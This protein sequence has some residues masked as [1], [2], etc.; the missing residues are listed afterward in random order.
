[1]QVARDRDAVVKEIDGARFAEIVALG[2]EEDE[3][4]EAFERR[5]MA[6][7][8]AP[9]STEAKEALQDHVVVYDDAD[10]QHSFT[11]NP[12]LKLLLR[13]FKWESKECKSDLARRP[14]F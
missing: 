9:P 8:V 14:P 5:K 2:P 7:S 10:R 1:M 12:Q 11:H 4:E 13:Q 6:L 3:D